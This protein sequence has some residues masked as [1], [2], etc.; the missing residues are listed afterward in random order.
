MYSDNIYLDKNKYGYGV[1]AGKNFSIGDIIE[2]APVYRLTN[3][4]GN[5]NPHFFTW[6]HDNKGPIWVAATGFFP[7]YN[8]SY[9]PNV[10]TKRDYEKDIMTMVATKKI[11]KNDELC[12]QYRSAAWRKV[13][14]DLQ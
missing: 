9:D 11:K 2:Y 12:H 6:G 14:Q 13:F 3:C 8:H 7:F 10:E 1:Y 4:D 5:E